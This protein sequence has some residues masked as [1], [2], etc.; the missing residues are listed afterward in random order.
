VKSLWIRKLK[1]IFNKKGLT[2]VEVLAVL[3]ILG[4]F[5]VIAIPSISSSIEKANTEVCHTNRVELE[6]SYEMELTLEN[7]VN[8]EKLFTMYVR[9]FG[10]Q[11][12]PENGVITYV[13]GEV[14]CSVHTVNDHEEDNEG[15]VPFL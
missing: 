4:I 2:L 15:E 1:G 3:V 10:E 5:V 6:E 8:N 14:N 9:E 12:C 11:I 13:D 7:L